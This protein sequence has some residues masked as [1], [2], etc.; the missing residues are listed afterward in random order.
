M[1]I[2]GTGSAGAAPLARAA[3]SQRQRARNSGLGWIY[4]PQ[5][6]LH[7]TDFS[8]WHRGLPSRL[9]SPPAPTRISLTRTRSAE[10]IDTQVESRFTATADSSDGALSL[11]LF[12][13]RLN[14]TSPQEKMPDAP[15]I[16]T[17]SFV[18]GSVRSNH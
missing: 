1:A 16:M 8:A 5:V 14:L 10:R 11:A 9:Q 18:N 7:G 17:T 15:C 13:N 4:T 12:E 2:T 3:F 6:M